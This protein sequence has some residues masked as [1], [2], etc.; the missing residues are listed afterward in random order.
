M[1]GV[2]GSIMSI[3]NIN[4]KTNFIGFIFISFISA[5]IQIYFYM[6]VMAICKREEKAE[7]KILKLEY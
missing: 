1:L 7:E 4:P 3:L 5:N 6:F 2:M